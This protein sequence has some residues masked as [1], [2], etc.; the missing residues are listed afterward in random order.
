MWRCAALVGA[1]TEGGDPMSAT[2]AVDLSARPLAPAAPHISVAPFF[3]VLFRI[4]R[5]R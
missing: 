4:D 5:P 2:G 3:L 1:A